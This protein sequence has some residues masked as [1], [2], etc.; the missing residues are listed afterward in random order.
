MTSTV[1]RTML[2]QV[3]D[4]V[5]GADSQE[6]RDK[7]LKQAPGDPRKTKQFHSIL[8]LAVGKEQRFLLTLDLMT[9]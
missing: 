5:I 4:S 9:V 7:I 3:H 2:C 1:E 6:L 8:H